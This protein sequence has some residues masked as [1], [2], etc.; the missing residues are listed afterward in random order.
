[1]VPDGGVGGHGG[2]GGSGDGVGGDGGD[3]DGGGGDGVAGGVGGDCGDGEA[4]VRRQH[5]RRH[6]V[7]PGVVTGSLFVL[8]FVLIR[9]GKGREGVEASSQILS[10]LYLR[11]PPGYHALE[12]SRPRHQPWA[13]PQFSFPTVHLRQSTPYGTTLPRQ[14]IR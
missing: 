2:D 9:L 10:F 3:G 12:S 6:V 1:M 13:H 4:T 14:R 5:R 8:Y 11:Q 7:F